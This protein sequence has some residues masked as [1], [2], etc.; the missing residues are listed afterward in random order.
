MPNRE[1]SQHQRN[2]VV[3]LSVTG[4]TQ[5]TNAASLSA[6]NAL[7]VSFAMII[8]VR[9]LL[10][11]SVAAAERGM[12]DEEMEGAM[13]GGRVYEAEGDKTEDEAPGCKIEGTMAGGKV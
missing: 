12:E 8:C 2:V 10:A 3:L 11:A 9:R 1:I 4:A 6:A 5:A 7:A 13:V